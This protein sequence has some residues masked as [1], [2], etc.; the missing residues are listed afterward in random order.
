MKDHQLKVHVQPEITAA[1]GDARN[2]V[3]TGRTDR[4]DEIRCSHPGNL[5]NSDRQRKMADRNKLLRML[6]VLSR[7]Q[8]INAVV[9]ALMQ[10]IIRYVIVQ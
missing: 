5:G 4:S 2:L 1:F 7:Q 9:H 6:F 3:H 10:K 8:R